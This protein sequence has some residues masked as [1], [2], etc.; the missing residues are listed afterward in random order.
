MAMRKQAV[1]GAMTPTGLG[2]GFIPL[3]AI[4]PPKDHRSGVA[5]VRRGHPCPKDD[6]TGR[7]EAKR[8]PQTRTMLC[9]QGR[10]VMLSLVCKKGHRFRWPFWIRNCVVELR[11]AF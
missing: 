8:T 6:R 5:V 3:C 11:P 7:F 9:S 2:L 1:N 10:V 4:P